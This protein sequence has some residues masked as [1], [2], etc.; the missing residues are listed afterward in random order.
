MPKFNQKIYQHFISMFYVLNRFFLFESIETKQEKTFICYC[1]ILSPLPFCV[2]WQYS[3]K[4]WQVTHCWKCIPW[5]TMSILEE[6]LWEEYDNASAFLKTTGTQIVKV[7]E[8]LDGYNLLLMT[9]VH[10]KDRKGK[11]D[12]DGIIRWLNLN[13]RTLFQK[14]DAFEKVTQKGAITVVPKMKTMF[15]INISENLTV[16]NISCTI[17]Y[18]TDSTLN[19]FLSSICLTW[20]HNI[21]LLIQE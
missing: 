8:K 21:Y 13:L 3:R 9:K 19:I 16:I 5:Q 1:I 10:E 2:P 11:Q 6:Q 17:S 14:S 4:Q 7:R 12:F 20:W 15:R 18:F